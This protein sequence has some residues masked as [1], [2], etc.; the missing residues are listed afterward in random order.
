MEH[1]FAFV[2]HRHRMD[3]F[4][5]EDVSE[6]LSEVGKYLLREYGNQMAMEKTGE[7]DSSPRVEVIFFVFFH[8]FNVEKLVCDV[9]ISGVQVVPLH[10]D[11]IDDH[12]YR[13]KHSEEE[14]DGPSNIHK[15]FVVLGYNSRW[16]EDERN[17]MD[18]VGR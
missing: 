17:G 8:V 5:R 12:S 15:F 7:E 2:D 11:E 6:I 1:R 13:I 10:E 18:L 14:N 3:A 16:Q 9:E 4:L